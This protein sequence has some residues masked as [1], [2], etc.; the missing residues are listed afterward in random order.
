MTGFVFSHGCLLWVILTAD[1]C[2]ALTRCQVVIVPPRSV[3]QRHVMCILL[4]HHVRVTI[5]TF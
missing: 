1:V 2:C 3:V 4:G 5:D